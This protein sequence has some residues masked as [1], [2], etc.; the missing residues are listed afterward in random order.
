MFAFLFSLS[1]CLACSSTAAG[2]T[3]GSSPEDVSG[4]KRLMARL[5]KL[6]KTLLHKMNAV[7]TACQRP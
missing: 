2:K 1:L 3:E 6:E 4:D 7:E 5:Q